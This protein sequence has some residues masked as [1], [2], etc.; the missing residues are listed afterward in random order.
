MSSPSLRAPASL[1]NGGSSDD[2]GTLLMRMIQ[3]GGM[4]LAISTDMMPPSERPIN[5]KGSVVSIWAM[6]RKA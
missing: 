4:R 1:Y 6:R 3:T 5:T 2:R